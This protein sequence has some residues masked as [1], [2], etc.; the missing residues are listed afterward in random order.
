MST[1]TDAEPATVSELPKLPGHTLGYIDSPAERAGLVQSLQLEGF[2]SEAILTFEGAEGVALLA[3]MMEGSQWGESAQKVLK[4]GTDELL[5]GHSV[6]CV[7]VAGDEEAALVAAIS[8][9]LGGRSVTHFGVL[10]DT[11][12][13]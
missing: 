13:T 2:A 9:Q 1:P 6:F 3:Q 11:R 8:T 12:L 7:K 10:V 4:K 5:A